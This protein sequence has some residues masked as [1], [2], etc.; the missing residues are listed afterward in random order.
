MFFGLTEQ[1]NDL[2]TALRDF[3]RA[4]SPPGEVRRLMG[5]ERGY[6][7]A[8]WRRM[9]AELGLVGLV[10]PE[11]YG[12]SGASFV[13][14]A[15]ALEEAGYAL[16]GGPLF[17][18]AVLAAGCL[19]LSGDAAAM[20]SYLPGIAA[21]EVIATAA[22]AG[23]GGGPGPGGLDGV[24]ARSGGGGYRLTGTRSWVLDG[25]AADLLLVPAWAD[26][27]L[28][29]FAV[30][31]T[32]PGLATA[33]LPVLDGTRRMSR[34]ELASVPARLV[35][36]P[37]AAGPVIERALQEAAVAL[38]AEQVG[39][40]RRCLEMAVGY[41]QVRVAFGRP[42]GGFQAVRHICADMYTLLESARSAALYAAWCVASDSGEVPAVASLTKAYCS[43]AYFRAAAD[44]IQL[45]GGIGFT[46]EHDCHL[47]FRRATASLQF[48]GSP[49]YH[50]EL[51][52][53]LIMA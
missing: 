17:A 29:L 15:V 24:Q 49:R 22:I 40:I 20:A 41:A 9:A 32:A 26:E 28:S 44:N 48:L 12:G 1:Q 23:P 2:R 38:G 42:I 35:G 7:E 14:L 30:D 46:W 13:E 36:A 52:A 5:T 43:D 45:H 19:R 51:I 18:S 21:G 47:L 37:G 33:P 4:S 53:Q 6:D 50:R 16:A 8:T 31:A 34:L 27:G 11:R 25:Q 39:G 10:I 3:F